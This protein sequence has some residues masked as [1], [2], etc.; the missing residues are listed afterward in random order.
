MSEQ[1]RAQSL[2]AVDLIANAGA[3]TAPHYG[4][5]HEAKDTEDHFTDGMNVAGQEYTSRSSLHVTSNAPVPHYGHGH[6]LEHSKDHMGKGLN[7]AGNSEV[8]TT[9]NEL[10]M[11]VGDVSVPHYGHGHEDKDT[12]DHFVNGMNVE[13]QE[14]HSRSSLFVSSTAT[15]PHYGH[16]HEDKDTFDHFG[17]GMNLAS[18]DDSFERSHLFGQ[19]NY[20]KG[21]EHLDTLS[22]FGPG[23]VPHEAATNLGLQKPHEKKKRPKKKRASKKAVAPGYDEFILRKEINGMVPGSLRIS[24]TKKP[25][26][27]R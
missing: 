26:G 23:M 22:H 17:V 15:V 10:L 13:G 1:A 6:E 21:H 18:E 4:G 11:A 25:T 3:V 20:G 2:G 14:D 24:G 7:I 27:W 8:D 19:A 9:K 16:G 12:V 5:G